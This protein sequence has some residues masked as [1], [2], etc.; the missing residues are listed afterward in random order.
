MPDSR[1]HDPHIE[2]ELIGAGLPEEH[3]FEEH[4]GS[5]ADLNDGSCPAVLPEG[6]MRCGIE[7]DCVKRR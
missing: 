6:K 7:R 1:H 3:T 4:A 5:L 2:G